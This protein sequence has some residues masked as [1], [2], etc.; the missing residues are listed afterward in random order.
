M[1]CF[2]AIH[3]ISVPNLVVLAVARS[4]HHTCDVLE[5]NRNF[6][7]DGVVSDF[8]FT[9]PCQ[10][11]EAGHRNFFLSLGGAW[12]MGMEVTIGGFGFNMRA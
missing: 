8:E 2:P 6:V 1:F 3:S 11:F 9:E 4:I 12:D 7:D 10:L 5:H